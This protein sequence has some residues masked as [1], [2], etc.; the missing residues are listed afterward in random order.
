MGAAAP[1]SLAATGLSAGGSIM[2]GITGASNARAQGR[3]QFLSSLYSA[4][5]AE[6]AAEMGELKATQT[7]TYM[8][9]QM[10]GA[11]ANID[12]VLANTNTQDNSPSNWA[13]R[14]RAQEQGDEAR[15]QRVSNIQLQAKADRNASIL[16]MMSGMNAMSIANSN[17]NAAMTNGILGAGGKLLSGLSGINWG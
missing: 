16:Y 4:T 8:R 1:L 13:V 9:N 5:Q 12:A 14:N 2:S 10:G 17:A 6:L 15:V 7:D 11:L 3:S